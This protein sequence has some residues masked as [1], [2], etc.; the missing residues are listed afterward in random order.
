MDTEV[1]AESRAAASSSALQPVEGHA[2]AV[3]ED[4]DGLTVEDGVRQTGGSNGAT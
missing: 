1:G 2:G 4:R 3:V